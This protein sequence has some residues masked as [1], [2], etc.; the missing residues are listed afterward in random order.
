MHGIAHKKW[1]IETTLR[2]YEI[3]ARD[4]FGM[5][6]KLAGEKVHINETTKLHS[7]IPCV[8]YTHFF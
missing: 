7:E 2:W 4:R 3:R 5:W 8:L 1:S 6:F